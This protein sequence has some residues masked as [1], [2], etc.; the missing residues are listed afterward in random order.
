M[1]SRIYRRIESQRPCKCGKS[2]VSIYS[3]KEKLDF[4]PYDRGLG[5]GAELKCPDNCEVIN[6]CNKRG[7]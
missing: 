6:N 5:Q 4:P 3:K 7:Y 1:G 2:I